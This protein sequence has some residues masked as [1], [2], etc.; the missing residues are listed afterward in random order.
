[1]RAESFHAALLVLVVAGLALAGFAAYETIHPSTAGVCSPTPWISCSKVDQ[2]GHTTTFDIPDWK[3]GVAGF[4][5]MLVLEIPLYVTWRRDLLTGMVALSG[6]GL[7]IAV[8]LGAIELAVIHAVC[9]VCFSAYL[10]DALVFVVS[11]RLLR[12]SRET[13]SEDDPAGSESKQASTNS[14]SAD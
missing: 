6:I 13:D 10:V 14:A 12:F 3:I 9:P 8:Y 1:M 2:S 11:L 4:L 7:A 5:A